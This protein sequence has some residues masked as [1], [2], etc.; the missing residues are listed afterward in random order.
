MRSFVVASELDLV[1][2]NEL[3]GW[4]ES[5]DDSELIRLDLSGVVYIDSSGLRVL[6]E[7]HTGSSRAAGDWSL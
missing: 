3:S 5:A 6:V 2:S 4:I 7:H 1:A